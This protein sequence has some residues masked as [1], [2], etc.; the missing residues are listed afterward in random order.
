MSVKNTINIGSRDAS[1]MMTVLRNVRRAG[2]KHSSKE[3]VK[4]KQNAV[5]SL[6]GVV[7]W[8]LNGM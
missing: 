2:L 4:Q 7:R 3:G 1:A 6:I 5:L 8:K